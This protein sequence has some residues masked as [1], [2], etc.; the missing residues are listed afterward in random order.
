MQRVAVSPEPVNI[1]CILFAAALAKTVWHTQR[2]D[3][4]GTVCRYIEGRPALFA[5]GGF[6]CMLG[7][8]EQGPELPILQ[9]CGFSILRRLPLVVQ[10]D[11]VGHDGIRVYSSGAGN[12]PLRERKTTANL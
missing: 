4:V 2:I 3:L 10:W 8:T 1:I 6:P 12:R 11:D 5:S 9:L 7:D